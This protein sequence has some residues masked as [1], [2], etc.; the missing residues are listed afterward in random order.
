MGERFLLCSY[1]LCLVGWD[2]D[3]RRTYYRSLAQHTTSLECGQRNKRGD[4]SV[5][6]VCTTN[7]QQ[8]EVMEFALIVTENGDNLSPGTATIVVSVGEA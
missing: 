2:N 5:R 1:C 3:R 8:I 6:L 4:A 7:P